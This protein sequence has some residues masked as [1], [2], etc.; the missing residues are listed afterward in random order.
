LLIPFDFAASPAA[1]LKGDGFHSREQLKG[2][3]VGDQGQLIHALTHWTSLQGA[4]WEAVLLSWI[5]K[6]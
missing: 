3:T 4:P 6:S 2:R 1:S 5:E